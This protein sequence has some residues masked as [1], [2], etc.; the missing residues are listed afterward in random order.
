MNYKEIMEGEDRTFIRD[1]NIADIELHML[2][3]SEDKLI[4]L[5]NR[6][7]SACNQDDYIYANNLGFIEDHFTND[8]W[9]LIYACKSEDYNPQHK[10]VQFDGY[11]NLKS[12]NTFSVH[13]LPE[14]AFCI[15]EHVLDNASIYE[16][17]NL[18]Y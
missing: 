17:L 12:L 5:N 6:Y 2:D 15:A 7:S 18:I 16:G 1:N 9:R 14:S 13:D 10:Y 8:L 3:L 4:D 11:K